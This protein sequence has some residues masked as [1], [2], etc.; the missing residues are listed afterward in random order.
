MLD[1]YI[2]CG[3]PRSGS[4][5]L[6]GL[7]ESTGRTG[8]PDSY[9]HRRRFMADWAEEW[10]L[11]Q[12]ETMTVAAYDKAYLEAAI[13]AGKGGSDVFGLRLMRQ[14]LDELSGILDRIYPG[15]P[16]DSARLERAFGRLLYIHLSRADKLAQAVSLVKAEQTGLWHKAPDGREIERLAPPQDPHYDFARLRQE[17]T[18]LEGDDAAWNVWFE[19]QGITPLRI[20]YEALA[21]D[22]AGTLLRICAALGVAAPP[23]GDIKPA[24]AKLSDAVSRDWMRRYRRDLAATP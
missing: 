20:D 24:V 9:Y 21:S 8:V 16:N 14:Y 12:P 23:I 5:L 19:A 4:T 1:G 6:C 17:V 3:T 22:P 15:L 13:K 7:L 18:T 2:L 10:Q 11:P